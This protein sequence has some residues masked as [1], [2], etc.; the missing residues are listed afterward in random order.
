ME[1]PRPSVGPAEMSALR[2]GARVWGAEVGTPKKAGEVRARPGSSHRRQGEP[3]AAALSWALK[4]GWGLEIERASSVEELTK[5]GK[6]LVQGA[7][8][9]TCSR[10]WGPTAQAPKVRPWGLV[11]FSP[12]D[13]VLSEVYDGEMRVETQGT[14]T[15]PAQAG[16]MWH[17]VL[18][19]PMA[20]LLASV[21][22]PCA[23]PGA[24]VL[25]WASVRT[26]TKPPAQARQCPR[27]SGPRPVCLCSWE[28]PA[29]PCVPAWPAGP[30]GLCA[31]DGG[32]LPDARSRDCFGNLSQPLR[33][34]GSDCS[35]LDTL[36]LGRGVGEATF[37]HFSSVQ[38]V[39]LLLRESFPP[40]APFRWFPR[41][42]VSSGCITSTTD[43]VGVGS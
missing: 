36:S 25:A 42:S 23:A 16:S 26:L 38:L 35:V 28:A 5:A 11:G 10:T 40:P 41:V 9:D 14:S 33:G 7:Q 34:A 17:C 18:R 20:G 43:G 27:G 4:E 30:R 29:S 31:T 21:Q 24:R 12:V 19:A 1:D 15:P 2:A 32:S 13:N 8:G 37:P 6:G 3:G 22:L 39:A